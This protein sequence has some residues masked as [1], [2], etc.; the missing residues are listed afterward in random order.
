MEN[1]T[2]QENQPKAPEVVVPEAPASNAAPAAPEKKP[3]KKLE[4][5]TLILIIVGVLVLVAAIVAAVILIPKGEKKED[6]TSEYVAPEDR[7][8]YTIER[9]PETGERALFGND[10]TKNNTGE[11]FIEY[12]EEISQASDSTNEEIFDAKI[13][14]AVYYIAVEEYD[15]A[16]AALN[17]LDK[18]TFS[19][20]EY[21]RFEKVS[22]D[23]EAARNGQ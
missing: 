8:K 16:A 11:A 6:G 23:L 7:P 10:E 1:P 13:A 21:S 22:A 20:D 3:A 4:K 18:S 12:Q 15:N 5:K 9:D 17:S 2:N 14:Q 19:D